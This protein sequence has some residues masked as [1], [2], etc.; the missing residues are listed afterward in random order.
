MAKATIA[1][2]FLVGLTFL[3]SLVVLGVATLALGSLPFFFEVETVE[4][5]FPEVDNLQLGDDVLV[6]GYRIGQVDD[7]RYEPGRPEAPIAV[8]CSLR[9]AIEI[10]DKTEFSIRDLGPLGG[11]YLEITPRP[12]NVTGPDH[13]RHVGSAPGGLF[14]QLENL[15]EKNEQRITETIETLRAMVGDASAGRQGTIA[16][17]IQDP[18]VADDVRNGVAEIRETFRKINAGEG[19]LG[20]FVS[21]SQLRDKLSSAVYDLS[22]VIAGLKEEK[23][24]IGLLLNNE[25]AKQD[26]SETLAEAREIARSARE[27]DGVFARLINDGELATRLEETV[28]DAHDILHK[29]NSGEGTLGQV[30]NNPK[31]WDELVRILVL[32]RETIEDLRENAPLSTFVNALFAAF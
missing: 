15:V 22:D 14:K 32:A 19:P 31:A 24:V 25:K 17:L 6:H 2:N 12:G 28:E 11:R 27:G 1:R 13:D 9:K 7:I 16:T 10:T 18:L 3:G 29:A 4:V 26:L 30:I 20:A 21:D 23:G 8:R 5:R